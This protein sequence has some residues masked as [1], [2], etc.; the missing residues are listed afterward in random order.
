M[1]SDGSEARNIND[2]LL[3][4]LY[5]FV[6]SQTLS[7]GLLMCQRVPGAEGTG[8]VV[9]RRVV[10]APARRTRRRHVLEHAHALTTI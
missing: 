2:S 3:K 10:V 5:I 1:T 4:D 6:I 7:K 8:G 9:R